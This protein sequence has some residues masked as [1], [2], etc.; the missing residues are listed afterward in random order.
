MQVIEARMTLDTRTIGFGDVCSLVSSFGIEC[1]ACDDGD[2]ACLSVIAEGPDGVRNTP[3][4]P[5]IE[6]SFEEID[7]DPECEDREGP[8]GPPGGGGGGGGPI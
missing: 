7:A 1:T 2:I 5:V 4:L 8:G 3:A 6:R